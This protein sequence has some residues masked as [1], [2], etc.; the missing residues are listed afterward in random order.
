MFYRG[1]IKSIL[2]SCITAWFRNYTIFDRNT[3]Q[4]IARTA[5]KITGVSLPSIADIY[6]TR[7][8][9]KASSIVDH[10]IHPSHSRCFC[11]GI[12]RQTHQYSMLA[13]LCYL[14]FLRSWS[15]QGICLCFTAYKGCEQVDCLDPHCAGHG[16][17][18]KGEYLCSPG[19]SGISCESLLPNCKEQRFGH[20]T[21]IPESGI[22]VC[23]PKWTDSRCFTAI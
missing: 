6:T 4:Q 15:V 18:V 10:P 16:I 17:C 7:C 8:I 5:E 12:F 19:W 11:R 13:H 22:C 2:S 23:Q 9:R 1:T 20:G 3:L 21:Y 14:R